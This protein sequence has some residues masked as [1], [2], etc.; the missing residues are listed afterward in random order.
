MGFFFDIRT[1]LLFV[2]CLIFILFSFSFGEV[3]PELEGVELSKSAA[4]EELT[5]NS[6]IKY[7]KYWYRSLR[8]CLCGKLNLLS[9]LI[10]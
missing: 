10:K 1:A 6:V 3:E 5:T 9:L 2:I 8:P 4:R 7:S